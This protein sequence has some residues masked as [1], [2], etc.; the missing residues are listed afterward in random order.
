MFKIKL[1]FLRIIRKINLL[2]KYNFC[3]S[4]KINGINITIPFINGIGIANFVHKTNWL[5]LLIKGFANEEKGMFVDVGVNIGQTL[6]RVKTLFPDI[7]YLGFEPNST[8]THY[9][10]ELIRKNKFDNCMV[11]NCALSTKVQNIILEKS[12]ADDKRASIVSALRPNSFTQY[13]YVLGVNFDALVFKEKVSF[14]KIDVEGAEYEVLS[15][16]TQMIKENQPIVT[17][18]VL[19][20][21]GQENLEFSQKRADSVLDLLHSLDYSIIQLHTN[22]SSIQ[23]YEKLDGFQIVQWTPASAAL[24][25]YIFYPNNKEKEVLGILNDLNK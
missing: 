21:H 24:N 18:E 20:G 23:S 5:D 15:G 1:L 22:K 3:F 12:L 14:V 25:D 17:C 6:I 19:D 16:M 2:Q 13:E 11:Y 4:K 10:Q 8:C 9:T 7:I